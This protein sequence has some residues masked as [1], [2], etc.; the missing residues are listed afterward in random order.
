VAHTGSI[1]AVLEPGCRATAA[2]LDAYHPSATVTFDPNVRAALI[3]D[4]DI[5][6]GRIDRWIERCDVVKASDEDLRWI[7]PNHSPRADRPDVAEPWPVDRRRDDGRPGG[8]R[9]VRGRD[10]A[11]AGAS[12]DRGWTPWGQA[13]RS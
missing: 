4:A 7:D 1:A 10:R 8:L 3:E 6:R 9:D 11:G 5:A 12:G 13:T 2:L